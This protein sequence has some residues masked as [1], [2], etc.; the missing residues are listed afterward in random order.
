M[1]RSGL[2]LGAVMVVLLLAAMFAP[3]PLSRTA[4]AEQ[5]SSACQ[6]LLNAYALCVANNP[7]EQCTAIAEQVAAHC[8]ASGSGSTSGS[9]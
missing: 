3:T 4:Q 6:G 5:A 2:I 8:G 1:K 9:Y 7:T